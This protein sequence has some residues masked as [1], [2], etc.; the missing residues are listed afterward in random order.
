MF[1]ELRSHGP[2]RISRG[3]DWAPRTTTN[4]AVERR[5]ASAL[6]GAQDAS[7]VIACRKA[8]PGCGGPHPAPSRRSIPL[9]AEGMKKEASPAR[10][11]A[12]GALSR[13]GGA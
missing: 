5:E 11:E 7:G 9:V 3:L 2:G 4:A 1:E 12:L 6:H 10:F 13:A 8:R